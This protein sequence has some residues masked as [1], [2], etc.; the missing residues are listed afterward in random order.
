VNI[1]R[2]VENHARQLIESGAAVGSGVG[3]EG[4]D[5]RGQG[6]NTAEDETFQI[7]QTAFNGGQTRFLNTQMLA[8][9]EFADLLHAIFGGV[10][11]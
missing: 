11:R 6:V 3:G 4:F 1:F 9:E 10:S 5:A 2:E 8:D 7:A